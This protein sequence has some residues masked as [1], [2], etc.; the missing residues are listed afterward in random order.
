MAT[1][2][3]DRGAG[4]RVLLTRPE[5]YPNDGPRSGLQHIV[6][7][8]VGAHRVGW[9]LGGSILLGIGSALAAEGLFGG[10]NILPFLESRITLDGHIAFRPRLQV[11]IDLCILGGLLIWLGVELRRR[12]RAD[13]RGAMWDPHLV[14]GTDPLLSRGSFQRFRQFVLITG[15]V[16]GLLTLLQYGVAYGW[17]RPRMYVGPLLWC[18]YCEDGFLETGTAVCFIVA[19]GLMAMAARRSRKI[20]QLRPMGMAAF[21]I[22][23]IFIVI[24]MEEISW[25]QRIVGWDTPGVLFSGNAQDETNLH[26]F[27]NNWFS[28]VYPVAGVVLLAGQ[29]VSLRLLVIKSQPLY[30]RC[31]LPHP[32]L[33]G[34]VLLIASL[35]H[36]RELVEELA[37]LFALMYSLRTYLCV[38]AHQATVELVQPGGA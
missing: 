26:N 32:G 22:G 16:C 15:I 5:A 7:S 4:D 6:S 35:G 2:K 19:G 38:H 24:G 34:F 3:L 10:R 36:F 33:L 23:T 18:V 13:R 31:L 21:A 14:F 17:I 8:I 12:G 20:L 37:G 27:F 28:I 29:L 9:S 30:L 25:G 1:V 11:L